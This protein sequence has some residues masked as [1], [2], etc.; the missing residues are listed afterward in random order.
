MDPA[1]FH[2]ECVRWQGGPLTEAQME[3]MKSVNWREIPFHAI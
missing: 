2:K 1:E 3:L